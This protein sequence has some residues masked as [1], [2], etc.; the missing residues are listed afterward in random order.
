LQSGRSKNNNHVV[1][2]RANI[3]SERENRATQKTKHRYEEVRRQASIDHDESP[4]FYY[5]DLANI[6]T[7]NSQYEAC[8]I[9]R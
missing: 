7:Q 6:N 3:R 8:A 1:Q 2:S 9:R 5:Y 4:H